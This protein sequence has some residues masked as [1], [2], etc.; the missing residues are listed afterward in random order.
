M[1]LSKI[2]LMIVAVVAV[3]V[4]LF[5]VSTFFVPPISGGC[6]YGITS[7]LNQKVNS[8]EEVIEAFS[9]NGWLPFEGFNKS[10]VIELDSNK[11]RDER[12]IKDHSLRYWIVG[13][14]KKG[15]G[16]AELIDEN[17]QIYEFFNCV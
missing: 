1:D 9:S 12:F 5:L 15:V 7:S 3:V 4:A 10:D 14:Y 11:V 8:S 2:V 6:H 16:R 13:F 17:G